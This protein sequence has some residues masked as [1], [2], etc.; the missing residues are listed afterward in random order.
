MDTVD[1]Q[2]P[3]G[4]QRSIFTH[5]GNSPV[6]ISDPV[7]YHTCMSWITEVKSISWE[8]SLFREEKQYQE[9]PERNH[10]ER[11]QNMAIISTQAWNQAQD[12]EVSSR[13][14]LLFHVQSMHVQ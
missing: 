11:L 2:N 9:S 4:C 13:N 7:L 3:V 12:V 1:P 6:A 14:T 10:W 5:I 8:L